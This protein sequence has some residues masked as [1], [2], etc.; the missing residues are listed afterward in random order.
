M[1]S[2][3]S[4]LTTERDRRYHETDLKL[5]ESDFFRRNQTAL[6]I[7]LGLASFPAEGNRQ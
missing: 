5:F 3:T 4:L 6:C 1:Y 7:R 2:K